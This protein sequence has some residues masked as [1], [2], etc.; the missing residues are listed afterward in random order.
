[1]GSIRPHCEIESDWNIHEARYEARLLKNGNDWYIHIMVEREVSLKP[2]NPNK[3]IAV[4]IG[5]R[6][7]ATKVELINGKIKK[8]KFYGRE[9]K[10]IRRHFYWLMKRLGEKKPLS[11]IKRIGE[12]EKRSVDDIFK[13]SRDIVDRAEL[14]ALIVIRYLKGLRKIQRRKILN[15]IVNKMPFFKLTRYVEYKA[16]WEG[17]PVLKLR[18]YYTSKICHRYGEKGERP[19]QGLFKCSNS[20]C[21]LEYNADLNG[22]ANLANL[23]KLAMGYMLIAGAVLTQ[24]LTQCE[25]ISMACSHEGYG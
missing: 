5:D 23:G 4:N 19:F 1:M 20:N 16:R 22:A 24:P 9:V 10:G 18:E 14:E 13:I 2:I 12:K 8:P 11:I 7:I 17:V 21:G 6:N 3:I 25:A 15:K